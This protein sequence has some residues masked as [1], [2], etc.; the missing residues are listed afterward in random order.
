MRNTPT[1][2]VARDRKDGYVLLDGLG[3]SGCGQMWFKEEE[4]HKTYDGYEGAP[5]ESSVGGFGRYDYDPTP[6]C[7]S[8]GAKTKQNCKCGPIAENE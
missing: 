1:W 8:C 2:I 6:Y 4:R 3:P 7:S 5:E